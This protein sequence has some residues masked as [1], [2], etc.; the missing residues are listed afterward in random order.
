M[1][2]FKRKY[3]SRDN[4]ELYDLVASL[5]VENFQVILKTKEDNYYDFY[6]FIVSGVFKEYGILDYPNDMMNILNLDWQLVK[7]IIKNGKIIKC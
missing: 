4:Q 6:E 3:V 2:T 1:F 5:S 7:L